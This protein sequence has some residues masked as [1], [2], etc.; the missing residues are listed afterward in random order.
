MKRPLLRR[1]QDSEHSLAQDDDLLHLSADDPSRSLTKVQLSDLT[2]RIAHCLRV[3]FGVGSDDHSED[4]VTVMSYGQP[5]LPAVYFGVIS[6]GGAY[7]GASPS[8][9]ADELAQQVRLAKSQIII[10]SFEVIDTVHKT[11]KLCGISSQN[12]LCIESSPTW[13][14][15]RS[16][17][18]KNMLTGKRLRW[19]R[20]TDE[21]EL[22]EKL[23]TIVWS[24]GT[25]GVPK[26]A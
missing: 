16:T 19:K 23:V 14:V 9:T 12:V 5:I 17:D 20:C 26:G 8:L 7:S 24:S 22:D 6:A 1:R 3:D 21:R 15:A 13:I 10:C 11:A 2:Q 4:V 18:G 25:T